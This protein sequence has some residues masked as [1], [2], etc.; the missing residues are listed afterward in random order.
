MAVV[1]VLGIDVGSK[2]TGVAV[3]QSLTGQAQPLTQIQVPARQLQASHFSVFIKEWSVNCI[4]IGLP[5]LADGQAHPLESAIHQLKEQ[6]ELAFALPVFFADETLTSHE[7]RQRFGKRA[8]YDS[9]AAAVMVE[10]FLAAGGY[11]I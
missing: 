10:D 1:W 5:Q 4:V 3:G 6:L 8:E 7:A 2:K 9:A 11:R